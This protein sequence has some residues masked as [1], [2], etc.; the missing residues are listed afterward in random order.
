[1]KQLLLFISI[2]AFTFLILLLFDQSLQM[3]A[4]H[5]A[6]GICVLLAVQLGVMIVAYLVIFVIV[7]LVQK[8]VKRIADVSLFNLEE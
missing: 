7:R 2:S 4:L 5:G 3:Y 8:A 6:L 1:M